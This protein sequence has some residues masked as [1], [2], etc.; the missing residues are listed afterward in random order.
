MYR[1]TLN[2]AMLPRQK[3][4][5]SS[6][7]GLVAG[8]EL[9]ER[10]R[11]LGVARVRRAHDLHDLAGGMREQEGL[12][13]R[14]GHVLAAH[15]EHVLEPAHEREPA[16]VVEPAE[17]AG[18]E[19]ALGVD[20]ERRLLGILVIADE[21]GRAAHEDLAGRVGWQVL[22][23]LGV[24]DPELRAR[25]TGGR[26]S[27]GAARAGRS[28]GRSRRSRRIPCSRTRRPASRTAA[29]PASAAA[30]PASRRRSRVAASSRSVAVEAR[31]VLHRE[32]DR[33]ERREGKR[34]PLALELVERRP[35]IEPPADVAEGAGRGDAVARSVTRPLTWKSGSG[36]QKRS[37]GVSSSAPA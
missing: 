9:H 18:V 4:I 30:S 10:R 14:G 35:G 16:L 8:P 29:A 21:A 20:R 22:A 33:L 36:V 2:V 31:L 23:G 37:S 17:V 26:S 25:R 11:D 24:D 28:Y 7:V 5:S 13:L 15:L 27:S 34:A 1:G 6:S 19:P 12:D 32:P 3:S